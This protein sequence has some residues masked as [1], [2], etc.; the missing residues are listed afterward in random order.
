MSKRI[1]VILDEEAEKALTALTEKEHSTM[2]QVVRNLIITGHRRVTEDDEDRS[3]LAAVRATEHSVQVALGVLN[4][5]ALGFPT[6]ASAEYQNPD[7]NKHEILR[8]AEK[9]ESE[10]IR[11]RIQAKNNVRNGE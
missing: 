10:K 7:L 4:S 11:K 8:G 2:S 1:I 5:I 6:L 3:V 9:V